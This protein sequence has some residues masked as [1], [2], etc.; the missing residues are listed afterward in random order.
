MTPPLDSALDSSDPFEGTKYRS[1][2]ILGKGG[3]GAA[4]VVEHRLLGTHFVCKVLRGRYRNN[5]AAVDRM[6]VEAQSLA[7]LVHPSIVKVFDF[8]F[9]QD[10]RPFIVM[11]R[12]QGNTLSHEL[13]ARGELPVLE[14]IT[15][16]KQLLSALSAAHALGIVH[17]D[18]K[19]DNLFLH[20]TGADRPILKVLDFG[21]AKILEGFSDAAPQP[22]QVP[23]RAGAIVGT[24]RFLSP[25]AALGKSVDHRADLYSAGVVLYM[26]LC[27]R[28][29]WD[30]ASSHASVF[31]AQANQV[32]TPP[33][34]YSRQSIAPDLESIVLT[35]MSKEPDER[36]QSAKAFG[37]ALTTV[38]ERQ[39]EDPP[40]SM[41]PVAIEPR[42]APGA[43]ASAP[44][45][46]LAEGSETQTAGPA[47]NAR[48]VVAG[49]VTR[50]RQLVAFVLSAAASAAVTWLLAERLRW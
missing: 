32:P 18:I 45:I 29:P 33:S 17:R 47:Y 37:A 5:A 14:A 6:R 1:L 43:A 19:L 40:R 35:A 44:T 23:T 9:T 30:D 15:I 11:E 21:V 2:S 20:N 26:L 39:E 50:R 34:R 38:A 41:T 36:F 28:G 16:T 7:R 46:Q 4:H 31:S 48:F 8:D 42:H 10:G 22:P 24:P 13:R 49:R 27:G 3:M 25:E 12:L